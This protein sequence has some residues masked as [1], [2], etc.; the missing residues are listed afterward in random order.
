LPDWWQ[1]LGSFN[2]DH[3]TK[4]LGSRTAQFIRAEKIRTEPLVKILDKHNFPRIDFL[5]VDTEGA[6]YG[7]IQSLDFSKF[8][9]VLILYE[10]RH[11]TQNESV[12]LIS[13]LRSHGYKFLYTMHDTLAILK[14]L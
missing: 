10:H 12:Q 6:D 9:P 2:K 3:I 1:Q 14:R 8:K 11:L 4:Y 7:V 5:H 13:L